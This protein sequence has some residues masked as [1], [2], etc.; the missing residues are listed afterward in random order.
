[1]SDPAV[2]KRALKNMDIE[3][4]NPEKVNE[5]KVKERCEAGNKNK[6]VA[7]RR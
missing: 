1:M 6:F 7:V 4:F 2:G 5:M 3:R